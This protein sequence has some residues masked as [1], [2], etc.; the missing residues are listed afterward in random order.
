MMEAWIPFF[1]ALVWPVFI[2]LLIIF[3]RDWFVQLLEIIR[4]RIESGSG[5]SIGPGGLSLGEAPK[6]EAEGEVRAAAAEEVVSQYSE[7]ARKTLPTE[8]PGIEMSRYFQ[9]IHSAE[10]NPE[11][12]RQRGQA[13]YTIK[14]RLEAEGES[15]L[16]QVSRVVYHLHPSFPQP[17]REI[18]TRRNNFELETYAWGQFNLSADVYFK[19]N[20]PPLK[21]FRYLNF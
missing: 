17:D 13:Y 3:F 19:D 5:I 20:D 10:Y 11:I 14:V 15:F 8:L 7:D 12:S 6:I 4:Q 1:Q 18:K 16:E 21:L 9:L 2:T